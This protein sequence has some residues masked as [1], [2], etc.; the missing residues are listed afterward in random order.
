MNENGAPGK[1]SMRRFLLVLGIILAAIIALFFGLRTSF[2]S[3]GV[4]R[5]VSNRFLD[6]TP[7]SLTIDHIE[8]SIFQDVTLRGVKMRYTGS[9]ESFDLFRAG[10]ISIRYDWGALMRRSWRIDGFSLTDP[11]LRLRTDSTGT[12][13][14]P[15]FGAGKG[16]PP[17]L[18]I[19]MFTIENGHVIVQGAEKSD[20]LDDLNLVGSIRSRA[21]ELRIAISQGSA[22]SAGRHFALRSLKGIVAFVGEPRRQGAAPPATSRIL[23]DSLAVVLDESAFTASGTIVPSTRLFDLAIEA[24]PIDIGEITRILQIETSH[25]GDFKGSLTAKGTTGRFRLDGVVSGVLSGYAL[26]DFGINLLREG[27]VIRLD[28]LSGVVNGARVEG[29]G[30]YTLE[31]PNVLSLDV[32]VGA[33][34]LSKGF[35][36]GKKLPATMFNGAVSLSYRVRDEALSCTLD[37]DEGSFLGFPFAEASARGSYANDTLRADEILIS[38]PTHTISASGTFV[39]DD[40]VSFIFDVECAASDTIFGY[41]DIEE[42]RADATLNGRWEGT[43]D[44]WDLRLNG[45]CGNLSY[46]GAFVPAGAVKLAVEKNSD[47]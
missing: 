13:M 3:R 6:G 42:Y 40:A 16:E 24:A 10:E 34:D 26:S 5:I 33:L 37:L 47:Y 44:E 28:T 45:S 7:Y 43:L 15:S 8:G 23:L 46:H 1:H 25:Y 2:F 29:R 41:F 17:S 14:V 4:G 30:A 22:E 12:F 36:P 21:D 19:T 11:V 31:A 18:D 38:H 27:D 35:V 39:G 20:A 32:E 9:G